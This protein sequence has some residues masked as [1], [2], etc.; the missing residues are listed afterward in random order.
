[1][2]IKRSALSNIAMASGGESRIT[3]VVLDGR[4][5]EWVGIGW[6]DITDSTPTEQRATLPIME[7]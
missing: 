6:I 3:K 4:V 1:M 7:D 2:K 5:M